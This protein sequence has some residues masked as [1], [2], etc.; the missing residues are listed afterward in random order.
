MN[1]FRFTGNQT[2]FFLFASFSSHCSTVMKIVEVVEDQPVCRTEKI[3][4]CSGNST[5]CRQVEVNR[6]H[7]ERRTVR[8]ARPQTR[9]ERIPSTLCARQECK[10]GRVECSDEVVT[11]VE[12]VPV[13]DCQFHPQEGCQ[14]GES[15]CKT[16]V[17]RICRRPRRRKIVCRR[18]NGGKKGGNR[19]Q[20]SG[21]KKRIKTG[22]RRKIG[23]RKRKLISV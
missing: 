2:L 17:R 23:G 10:E 13:E 16:I 1:I 18:R 19:K 3:D 4:S 11:G 22:R 21:R 20:I 15:G 9:C 8:R 7:I 5:D 12:Q 6:C 14:Q